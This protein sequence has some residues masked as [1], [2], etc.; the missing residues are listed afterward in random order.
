MP[1]TGKLPLSRAHWGSSLSHATPLPRDGTFLISGAGPRLGADPGNI[2]F[3]PDALDHFEPWFV[4]F[5]FIITAFT[6]RVPLLPF[7]G[8]GIWLMQTLLGA[9]S[10]RGF[11][12]PRPCSVQKD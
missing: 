7:F 5:S 10:R 1:V 6:H 2:R 12:I 3:A 8:F 4:D 9:A 11:S